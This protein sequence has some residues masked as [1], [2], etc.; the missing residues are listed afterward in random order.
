[1]ALFRPHTLEQDYT[2]EDPK[3]QD[4][5]AEQEEGEEEPEEKLDCSFLDNFGDE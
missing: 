2:E 5:T 4:Y 3:G 1:M